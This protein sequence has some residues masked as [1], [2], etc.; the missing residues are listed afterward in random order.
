LGQINNGCGDL[1]VVVSALAVPLYKGT[2]AKGV[3]LP[4]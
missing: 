1:E 2:R 3:D 4:T